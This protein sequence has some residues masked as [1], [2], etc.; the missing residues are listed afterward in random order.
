MKRSLP[1]LKYAL[2][3]LPLFLGLIGLVEAGEPFLDALFYSIS[4]YAMGFTDT[5]PNLWVEVGRWLA[6]LATASGVLLAV[7]AI[8]DRIRAY[9]CYCRGN[10]VAV[11]GAESDKTALLDR[12]GRRGIDGGDRFVRAHRYILLGGDGMDFIV[13]NRKKLEGREV[14]LRCSDLPAQAVSDPHLWL[15][16][17]EEIAARLFWK[18][19]NLYALS[20][21]RGHQLS[22]V[23]LGFGRLGENLLTY[24]LQDNIFSPDQKITYHIFGADG[25]YAATHTQLDR[26]ED[27]VVFWD[28]PWYEQLSQLENADLILVLEQDGQLSLLQ[29]LLLATTRPQFHVF[30]EGN[31]GI[32]LLEG[33]NRLELIPWRD[34]AQSPEYIFSD[35]LYHRAKRINLRYAHLYGGVEENERTL[36]EQW[37]MLDAFTRYSNISSAD[38]HEMCRAML[39]T[40]GVAAEESALSPEL[41]ELLAELEHIRWCRYHYLNNWRRGTPENGKRKDAARRIHADLIPYRKLTDS[42]KEKDREN[43]RVLLSIS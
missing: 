30:T 32:D 42:E 16:C 34:E 4:M 8:R 19:R 5:P 35:V 7:I 12:L 14:Y 27:P 15:F 3:I 2:L 37:A 43:I 31:A 10:S 13:Q 21:A 9:L 33:Q 23:F 38:Y 40:M 1:V 22:I 11:Y 41:L 26:I 25:Q 24:G 39:G 6:P 29:N 20:A 28:E 36:E 18:K 17:P